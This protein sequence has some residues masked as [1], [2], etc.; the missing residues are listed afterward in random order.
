MKQEKIG[1][2]I[3]IIGVIFIVLS[4]WWW[5]ILGMKED[6]GVAVIVT[7]AA[8]IIGGWITLL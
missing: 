6:V 7:S 4:I 5:A 2:T 3:T 8:L 1:V